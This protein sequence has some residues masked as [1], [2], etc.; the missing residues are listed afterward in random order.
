MGAVFSSRFGEITFTDDQVIEV[1]KGI[2]GFARYSKYIIMER[3][4]NFPFKWLHCIE[5]PN[6]AFVLVDPLLFFPNYRIEPEQKD[7]EELQVKDQE[8]LAIYV[9]V[10]ITSDPNLTSAN[11]IAPLVLNLKKKKAK[12]IVLPRSPYTIKHYL[13]HQANRGIANRWKVPKPVSFSS[14][15]IIDANWKTNRW[16]IF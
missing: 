6:L 5:D 2:F 11:L 8:E 3:K 13:F 16:V 14:D 10:T 15:I 12:Q 7:L 9:I 4:E 1:R